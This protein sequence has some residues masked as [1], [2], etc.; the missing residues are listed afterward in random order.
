MQQS[1]LFFHFVHTGSVSSSKGLAMVLW[2]MWTGPDQ[3][4]LDSHKSQLP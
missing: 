2:S 1:I 3:T 4:G